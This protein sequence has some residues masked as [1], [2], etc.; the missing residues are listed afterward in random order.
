MWGF[1]VG[2][3][4]G[5]GVHG[6]GFR[7]VGTVHDLGTFHK[8]GCPEIGDVCLTLPKPV[9]IFL[10]I[11][12]CTQF[13]T[14]NFIVNEKVFGYKEKFPLYEGRSQYHVSRIAGLSPA[15]R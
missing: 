12:Y 6:L 3:L 5:K 1:T 11:V 2:V 9:S 14:Y 13:S 8:M 7:K 4:L 15:D 10:G